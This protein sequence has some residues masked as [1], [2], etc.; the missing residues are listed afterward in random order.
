MNIMEVM[1]LLQI[2][3]DYARR[4]CWP[5][6]EILVRNNINDIDIINTHEKKY[7]DDFIFRWRLC[8]RY[9][10]QFKIRTF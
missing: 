10:D 2:E 6:E 7:L 3:V 8:R 9:S 4:P 1:N 5:D